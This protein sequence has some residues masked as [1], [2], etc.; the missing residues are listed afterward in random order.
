MIKGITFSI[1]K[2]LIYALFQGHNVHLIHPFNLYEEN[3]QGSACSN[4]I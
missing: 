2:A 4:V 3:V 1:H